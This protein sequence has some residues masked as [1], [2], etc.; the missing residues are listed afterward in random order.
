MRLENSQQYTTLEVGAWV[1]TVR[2]T[3]IT[4]LG[5]YHPLLGS[6]PGN[7]NANFIEE[8]NQLV[9]YFITIH[10]NQVILRD[11]TIHIQELGTQRLAS[12]MIQLR[13]YD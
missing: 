10:N 1:T 9:H 12:T 4:I 6:S 7:T 3:L 11:L 8:V 13:H 5:I 2:N